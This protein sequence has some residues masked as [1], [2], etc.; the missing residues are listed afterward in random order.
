MINTYKYTL[1]VGKP[2][3][4]KKKKQ[5]NLTCIIYFCY[6]NCP[7]ILDFTNDFAHNGVITHLEPDILECKVMWALESIT[8]NKGTGGDEI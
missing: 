2:S 1:Q 3:L 8:T 4:G 7:V 5:T 6:T